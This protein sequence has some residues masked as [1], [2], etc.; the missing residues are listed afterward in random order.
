MI[1]RLTGV[2]SDGVIDVNGVGYAVNYSGEETGETAVFRI[3]TIVK[4]DSITLW[5]FDSD[6]EK[7]AFAALLAVRNV[8]PSIAGAIVN[9]VGADGAF[10]GDKD[11][12]VSVK[13]V[14]AKAAENIIRELKVPEGYAA[15][16]Y[17]EK[18]AVRDALVTLGYPARK[19]NA[20]IDTAGLADETLAEAIVKVTGILS[21]VS[22]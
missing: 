20:A 15:K 3:H 19:V 7:A 5:A 2:Y 12:L 14:G 13:G 9:T 10:S 4:E 22:A 6:D 18:A 17:P 16:V 21:E 11:T 8:G 1:G